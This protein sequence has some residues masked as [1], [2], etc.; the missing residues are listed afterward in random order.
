[1]RY[2]ENKEEALSS[3]TVAKNG[4]TNRGREFL[5]SPLFKEGAGG[6]QRYSLA[7]TE[8]VQP[9][10]QFSARDFGRPGRDD[11]SGM[12]PP[13]LAMI[14]INL[15]QTS[16]NSILLDPF[17]GSGTILSEALLLGYKNLIGSDI[18]EKAVEDTKINID[19]IAKEFNKKI[20]FQPPLVIPNPLHR[21]EESLSV[22]PRLGGVGVG[23]TS[24]CPVGS[25]TSPTPGLEAYPAQ[26]GNTDRDPSSS[27]RVSLPPTTGRAGG[28]TTAVEIFKSG[29][30]ELSKN[31]RANSIDAIV[32]EPLLGK[33]LR[34]QETKQEL[35]KQA[36]ELKKLYLEA[37]TQFSK[38]L[39][40]QGKVVFI[41]P[42][43]KY[44]DEWITIDCKNEI[45]KIG[46]TA[47][48]FFEDQLRLVYS[49]PNQRVAREIWRFE[50]TP[51]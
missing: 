24:E 41:I 9:F 21:G 42:R 44:A 35:L 4:L 48:P 27:L 5:I 29:V 28:M 47:L 15:A 3:V 32:A 20:S 39:K 46:F 1:M 38:I 37:F 25:I 43:F 49:R 31:L 8:A 10:E 33:P 23:E 36:S 45:E 6:G 19:W 18:S 34:G 12:L 17:C 40:H 51:K 7:K 50:K 11:L 26:A 30:A 16:L 13:K 2:V 14:M 22:I